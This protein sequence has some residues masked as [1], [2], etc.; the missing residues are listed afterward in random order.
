MRAGLFVFVVVAEAFGSVGLATGCFVGG[1]MMGTV[2]GG[3]VVVAVAFVVGFATGE[4]VAVAGAGLGTAATVFVV[5]GGAGLGSMMRASS[6]LAGGAAEPVGG[7][8]S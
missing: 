4:C 3:A 2:V 7:R 5:V 8:R 6:G 1:T